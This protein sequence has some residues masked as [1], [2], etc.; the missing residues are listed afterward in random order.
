MQIKALN[1]R[2]SRCELVSWLCQS[3]AAV[4]LGKLLNIL[5]EVNN[6]PI[7]RGKDNNNI[8]KKYVVELHAK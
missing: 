6:F 1:V 4:T 3:L 8:L 5:T 7:L 2:V